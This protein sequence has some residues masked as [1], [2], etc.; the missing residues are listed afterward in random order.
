MDYWFLCLSLAAGPRTRLF[1]E[2]RFAQTH[3]SLS[4][5]SSECKHASSFPSF[6]QRAASRVCKWMFYIIMLFHWGREEDKTIKQSIYILKIKLT[7]CAPLC[8]V[9]CGIGWAWRG[10]EDAH[11]SPCD[12]HTYT[13]THTHTHTHSHPS[14]LPRPLSVLRICGLRR[15]RCG[16]KWTAVPRRYSCLSYCERHPRCCLGDRKTPAQHTFHAREILPCGAR[17]F[18]S[19]ASWCRPLIP[20][21]SRF[22]LAS[23]GIRDAGHAVRYVCVCVGGSVC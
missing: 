12:S 13:H 15:A 9:R 19:P 3:L 10:G 5:C 17:G 22:W 18:G 2:T 7:L 8:T 21:G 14:F 23:A 1:D 16:C 11:M 20:R 4:C 6:L